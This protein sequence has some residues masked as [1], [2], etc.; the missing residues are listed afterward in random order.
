[1]SRVIRP[2][3][4]EVEVLGFQGCFRVLSHDFRVQTGSEDAWRVVKRMLW[5][6]ASPPSAGLPTYS[7]LEHSFSGSVRVLL[8]GRPAFETATP[9]EALE[10]LRRH[11][12]A[13][14][15]ARTDRL[16]LLRAAVVSREGKA[17]L[18]PA[19]P[20]PEST[21][22][23]TGLVHAGF[24]FLSDTL[25]PYDP[26]TG[27]VVP[28]PMSPMV[29]RVP[30]SPDPDLDAGS[31]RFLNGRWPLRPGD[32]RPGCIG[33]AAPVAFVFCAH[34]VR[35]EAS[36]APVSRARALLDL[37]PNALNLTSLG[38]RG[39]MILSDVVRGAR[40]YHLRKVDVHQAVAAIKSLVEE[41]GGKA[42]DN[43][44][45]QD[46][47]S[48]P[49]TGFQG[50]RISIPERI[51]V[52]PSWGRLHGQPLTHGQTVD[53]GEIIGHLREGVDDIPIVSH[54]KGKF[55]AWLSWEGDRVPPGTPLARLQAA[56]A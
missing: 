40:C 50:E 25:A 48:R 34:E 36:L 45:D 42:P 2:G 33:A 19:M 1:M 18:V 8:E 24:S 10:Y 49:T 46:R 7:V 20:E 38:R 5:G 14:A 27:C 53:E 35:G 37:A 13:E 9:W 4:G 55:L 29:R 32:I 23:V 22:L 51:V 47:S 43:H 39:I 31:L 15:V 17:I 3:R 16:L 41:Q 12:L 44:Q 26:A 52:S 6:F 54:A 30:G 21:A 28:F 56:E 11:I